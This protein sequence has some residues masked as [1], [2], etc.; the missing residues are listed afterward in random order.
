MKK[1]RLKK[2]RP[3]R[4][5]II[6]RVKIFFFVTTLVVI[7]DRLTKFLAFKYLD[8]T[9]AI[10]PG[11][12]NFK[13]VI[14]TGAAFSIFSGWTIFLSIISALFIFLIIWNIKS[15]I[16]KDYYYG[17]ALVLGGAVSNLFDRIVYRF[18]IDFIE[19]PFFS[20][21]NLADISISVGAAVII[22]HIIIKETLCKKSQS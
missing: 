1:N 8:E 3:G 9:F 12:L 7:F 20:V 10:I 15:L 11:F 4:E 16:S 18:V 21:F 17:V 2:R 22:W 5:D 14:N 6:G 19:V 13:F